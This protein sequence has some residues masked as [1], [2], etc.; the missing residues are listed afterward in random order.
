MTHPEPNPA[1]EIRHALRGVE[2]DAHDERIAAWALRM[3]DDA[4][5]RTL[6]SWIERARAAEL[7]AAG[8]GP[9]GDVDTDGVR[10]WASDDVLTYLEQQTG[11]RPARSTWEAYVARGRAPKP[12]RRVGRTPQWDADAIR[13]WHAERPGQAWR[14]G[15]SSTTPQADDV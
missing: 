13:R 2:L 10:W 6:L 5:L 7:V 12:G 3:L 9:A 15:Q 14:A 11:T 4:T 1:D 8:V